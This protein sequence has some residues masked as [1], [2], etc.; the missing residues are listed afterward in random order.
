[1]GGWGEVWWYRRASSSV[2]SLSLLCPSPRPNPWLR[3][4]HGSR[5]SALMSTNGTFQVSRRHVAVRAHTSTPG[6]QGAWK[7]QHSTAQQW[8]QVRHRV[9]DLIRGRLCRV[10]EEI[11]LQCNPIRLSLALFLFLFLSLSLS[12]SLSSALSLSFFLSPPLQQK[13]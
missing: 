7:G 12:L 5:Q 11:A 1:M 8:P 2:F 9:C 13:L 3:Q 4:R 6:A 10:S